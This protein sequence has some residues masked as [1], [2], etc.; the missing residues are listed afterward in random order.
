M[1]RGLNDLVLKVGKSKNMLVNRD[2]VEA[3][4]D[5]FNKYCDQKERITYK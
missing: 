3:L 1:N 4:I 2:S 5:Y